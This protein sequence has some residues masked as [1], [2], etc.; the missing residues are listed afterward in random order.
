MS[1]SQNAE[2]GKDTLLDRLN[3]PYGVLECAS[4]VTEWC[5]AERLD[6]D[7]ALI[8][9]LTK[10]ILDGRLAAPSPSPLPPDPVRHPLDLNALGLDPRPDEAGRGGQI[11]KWFLGLDRTGVSRASP[12]NFPGIFFSRNANGTPPENTGT[13]RSVWKRGKASAPDQPKKTRNCL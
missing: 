4:G 3:D 5:D 9:G 13:A 2:A 6:L 7:P 1:E 12:R 10:L 11:S 8:L